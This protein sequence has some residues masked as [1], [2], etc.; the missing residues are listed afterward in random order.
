[1]KINRTTLI[2]LLATGALLALNPAAR[3]ADTATN[4]PPKTEAAPREDRPGGPRLSPEQQLERMTAELKLTDEQ[5]PKVKAALEEQAKERAGLRDLPQEERRAKWRAMR[6]EMGKKLKTILTDEQYK[7]W[8]A[9]RPNRPG[10]GQ[11]QPNSS[12][13]NN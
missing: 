10:G 5:K 8:E 6:E 9:M 11:G 7:K 12:T 13:P 4:T 1:M 2:A 3:A